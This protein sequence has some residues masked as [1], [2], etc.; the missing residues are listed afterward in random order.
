MSKDWE[1]CGHL[2]LCLYSKTSAS[3]SWSE[4][5]KHPINGHDAPRSCD[6]QHLHGMQEGQRG[7][8]RQPRAQGSMHGLCS[9]VTPLG[10]HVAGSHLGSVL[11]S[12]NKVVPG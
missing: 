8:Y 9:K 7:V 2:F 10:A 4:C 5:R 12:N 11:L 3:P 1:S 6:L